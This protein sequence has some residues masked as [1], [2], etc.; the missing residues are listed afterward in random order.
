MTENEIKLAERIFYHV[1]KANINPVQKYDPIDEFR[2]LMM[3]A[4]G[5]VYKDDNYC[6]EI[7][8]NLHS[9]SD[10]QKKIFLKRSGKELPGR[11]YIEEYP[12]K[13]IVRIGFK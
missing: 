6:S 7:Y 5:L 10:W 4:K 3:I 13:K 9:L 2:P 8:V 1:I 11:C 12:D